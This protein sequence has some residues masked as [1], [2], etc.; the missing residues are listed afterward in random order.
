MRVG[1]TLLFKNGYCFQSYGWNMLRPLGRL[2]NALNH[3]DQYELDEICVLRPV[4]RDDNTFESDL[5]ELKKAKSS[6]PIAFGGGIRS[7]ELLDLLEGVPVERFVL[8][9]ALFY[10][11]LSIIY[12]ICSKY[13]EQSIVGFIPFSFVDQ[14]LRLFNPSVNLFQNSKSLNIKSLELCDEIILHDCDA[15]GSDIG[16]KEKIVDLMKIDP[17]KLIFSGGV[18]NMLR[19][20][21]LTV[22]QPKSI[23]VE[24]K[25]LHKENSIKTFYGT[26]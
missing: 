2:Q 10:D 16:F 9:S 14:R 13:G 8:S 23:L 26:M 4:R 17:K 24:N 25:I 19:F 7:L 1:T 11:D 22:F 18:S 6:T 21:D 20:K 12:R 5:S 15:E 3:L